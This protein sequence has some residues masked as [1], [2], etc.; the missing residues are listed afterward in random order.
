MSCKKKQ[1]IK[2][3][4]VKCK[5]Q[6]HPY[7]QW[8]PVGTGNYYKGKWNHRTMSGDGIYVMQNGTVYEGNFDDG[9]FHGDGSMYYP[10]GSRIEGV[11]EKGKCVQ[12]NYIFSDG[13][14]FQKNNWQ[15][16]KVP[17]RRFAVEHV[18]GFEPAARSKVTN[19]Q[20]TIVVPNGAYDAGDGFYWL[21]TNTVHD[22][23]TNE[24]IR[25]PTAESSNWIIE[26]CHQGGKR[27]V[28]FQTEFYKNWYDTTEKNE[29]ESTA[30][31]SISSEQFNNDNRSI[32]AE[33]KSIP[34]FDLSLRS[35]IK[36]V[37][38]SFPLDQFSSSSTES[39]QL[40]RCQRTLGLIDKVATN[41]N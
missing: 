20:S 7:D 14:R 27:V 29:G 11:W 39:F 16:C 35:I 19:R 3:I 18:N 15:Y 28:G 8:F 10:S 12:Q 17:D 5:P 4:K 31:D 2:K 30:T 23:W 22:Y 40:S 1:L 21:H 36:S 34:W 24:L 38:G 9:L 41:Y 33:I 37:Q 32:M 25:V 13:L 6:L 26:N